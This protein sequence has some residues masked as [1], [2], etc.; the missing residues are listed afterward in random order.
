MGL[1]SFRADF[2]KLHKFVHGI[3]DN[4]VVK[5][6]VLGEKVE[7]ENAEGGSDITNSE[8]AMVHEF[9]SITRNIPKRSMLR[10]P[11]HEKSAAIISEGSK[12]SK[13]LLAEGNSLQVL[14]NFGAAALAQIYKAFDTRGFGSW[15]PDE[16][17]TVHAKGSSQVLVDRGELRRSLS[18]DVAEKG[19]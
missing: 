13:K 6:G 18:F 9:G 1:S 11:L 17:G 7:R 2:S 4:H 5:V 19:A 15:A 3:E 10:M 8:I 12:G 16:P 14:R